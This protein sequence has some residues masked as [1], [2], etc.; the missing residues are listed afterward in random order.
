M[1]RSR[2]PALAARALLVVAGFVYLAVLARRLPDFLSNMVP[3]SDTISPVLLVQALGAPD[4]GTVY[5]GAHP[6]YSD[7][8]LAAI[9]LPIEPLRGIPEVL[10][11]AT[12]ILG[13][14]LV[15][16]AVRRIAGWPGV[17]LSVAVGIAATPAVLFNETSPSGRVTTLANICL[18]GLALVVFIHPRRPDRRRKLRVAVGAILLGAVTGF[19]TASDPL[20]AVVG[21]TPF[22]ITGVVVLWLSFPRNERAVTTGIG[23]LGVGVV[24]VLGYVL[25]SRL[26]S[27]VFGLSY[28][29]PPVHLASIATA[30]FNLHLLGGA[31]RT[32][33]GGTWSYVAA[34]VEGTL[35]AV[36]GLLLG[37]VVLAVVTLATRM[38]LGSRE[39]GARVQA[40]AAWTL[41]WSLVMSTNVAIF[42]CTDFPLDL[43]SIRYLTPMWLALVALLPMFPQRWPV[44]RLA[45]L[46]G[47][48]ALVGA[49][50]WS[51]ATL[52]P[53]PQQPETAVVQTLESQH[54]THGY[55]DYWDANIITW[56]TEG[57]VTVRQVTECGPDHT[58]LCP[59]KV[60]AVADWFQ[61]RSGPVA[62]LVDPRYSVKAPPSR[63]YGVPDRLIQVGIVSIYVYGEG[64]KLSDP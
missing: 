42:L 61:P 20:L 29:P 15:A 54:I 34:G 56:R 18:L 52:V 35:E 10:P 40:R 17:L 6:A 58:H 37:L 47:A 50:A 48:A 63:T 60:N 14:L 16:V 39:A 53:T 32:A 11:Y 38:V 45:T 24:S 28:R 55:A 8:V 5:L 2:S 51:L 43:W 62:V 9:G 46:I 22:V 27:G 41:F 4:H 59:Y 33:F 44:L 21:L 1:G 30:D 64:L 19:D 12:Y 7:L 57:K 31:V 26:G 36:V 49:N 3:S 23:A 13:M 25:T